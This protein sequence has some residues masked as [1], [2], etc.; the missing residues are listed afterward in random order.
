LHADAFTVE[1]AALRL[2]GLPEPE[3]EALIVTGR[4]GS[5]KTTAVARRAVRSD[6][7]RP[8]IIIC[9]SSSSCSAMTGAVAALGPGRPTVV[10]TLAGHLA[11]WMRS[12]YAAAGVS[13]ELRI[14]DGAAARRMVKKA[15][16]GLLD[17]SW[18]MLQ[19][20]GFDINIPG[21]S[22]PDAFLEEAAQLIRMLRR[23]RIGVDEFARGCTAGSAAF[24]GEQYAA[25][26]RRLHD[27]ELCSRLSRRARE[28]V[29]AGPPQLIAQQR[30]ERDLARILTRL[31]GEYIA[32]A[33]GEC[34]WSEEDVIDHG[35]AWLAADERAAR[36]VAR[37]TSAI[38][39]DD[40]E[41][42][43]PALP[44]LLK[45]LRSA[46][47]AE[48]ALAGCEDAQIG[49]LLGT[50]S[51]IAGDAGGAQPVAL[52]PRALADQPVEAMRFAS[53]SEEADWLA[54]SIAD[55]LREGAQPAEIAVLTRSADSGAVY[56]RLL[57]ER[58]APVCAPSALFQAPDD[59]AD[60]LA[61]AAVVDDA[62]DHAHLLRVLSSPLVGLSDQSV[63]TL[64]R[65]AEDSAQLVLDIGARG[66]QSK[67]RRDARAA[68]LSDNV[69]GGHVD[70]RL[71]DAARAAL[72]AL[73]ERF[74]SWEAHSRGSA[75]AATL[76]HL[77]VDGGFGDRWAAAPLH[78]RARLAD[79]GARLVE[80]LDNLA[81]LRPKMRLRDAVRSLENGGATQ[82][83]ARSTPG[84][85]TCDAIACV[86][87]LRF[88]RVFVAGVAFERFPRIYVSRGLAFTRTYGLIARENVAGGA[89]QTAKF[90]WYYAKFEAKARYLEGERRILRYGLS[91]ANLSAVVT[92]F[93][94]PPAW[95]A[96]QDL[97][98]EFG[99]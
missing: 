3:R 24:Y 85:I 72:V 10:D 78:L 49:A 98:A 93:G 41:D 62:K 89:S 87:G 36:G 94:K 74:A 18:P 82:R 20:P 53:E 27:P 64:S 28:A 19:E 99:A 63:W 31:Y 59:I 32:A 54:R 66:G 40:A 70:D 52:T 60:L 11:C 84:S 76:A 46:G 86:K 71:S 26:S 33:A 35:V 29:R 12:E 67:L 8:A 95:A 13:P 77:I 22:R 14:G 7:P 21:L 81:R 15:A 50:R 83:A 42:A 30:A 80:A 17:M 91:R 44:A 57:A 55:L 45:I 97:L 48:R 6:D 25:V 90:G 16:R 39:V 58:G 65:P 96:A 4:P 69:F 75:S 9:P 88:A 34:E 73:R 61:L 47:I 5:G 2:E 51:A 92:G 38:F 23:L 68:T 37:R 56:A 79:D 43:E 1:S